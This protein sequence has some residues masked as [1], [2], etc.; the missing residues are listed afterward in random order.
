L[1]LARN[2]EVVRETLVHIVLPRDLEIGDVDLVDDRLQLLDEALDRIAKELGEF[3]RPTPPSNG[4]NRST[5]ST[6]SA[7]SSR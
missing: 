6:P 2:R 1:A 5:T 7:N 4:K 3:A